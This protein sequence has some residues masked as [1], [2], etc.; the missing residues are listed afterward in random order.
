M[1]VYRGGG[2]YPGNLVKC[3]HQ[4]IYAVAEGCG[5]KV[6]LFVDKGVCKD[7]AGILGYMFNPESNGLT[8]CHRHNCGLHDSLPRQ[9]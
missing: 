9:R 3:I 1:H 2:A 8:D 7:G 6:Q 4:A 5:Q